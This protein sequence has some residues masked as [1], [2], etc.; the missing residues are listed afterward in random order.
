MGVA[1]EAEKLFVHFYT[2][3]GPKVKDLNET[4]QKGKYARL[5]YKLTYSSVNNSNI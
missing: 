4:V 1:D 5:C 2:K 3:G